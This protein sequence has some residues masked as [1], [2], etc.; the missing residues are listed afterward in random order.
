MSDDFS[1]MS[2]TVKAHYEKY[3][4]PDF[5]RLASVRVCDTYALNLESLWARFNGEPLDP[6][7]SRILLAGCGSFS[8]YPTAVANP[9][10]RITALD[11]S[12]TNLRKAKQ[13]T[14][15]H[16]RFNVDFIEG[17]LIE[18]VDLFGEE[19]FHFIDCYGV[20]HHMRDDASA[21]QTLHT[22]LKPG[23]FARIMVYSRQ[24]RR[25][26]QAIRWAMRLLQ[27]QDVRKL[28]ALCRSAKAGSRFRECLDATPEAA[29]DAGLA[30]LF[31][32]PYA[33]TYTLDALLKKLGRA[34]LEPLLF[35]HPGAWA[36]IDAEMARLRTLE[37]E[38]ALTA[39]FILF[40]GRQEDAWMRRGW[41]HLKARRATC[42]SLN[43]VIRK[44]LPL[45][46]ILPLKPAPKLGFENPAIDLCGK[47]LLSRFKKPV[48]RSSIEPAHLE[49][50]EKYLQALFLIET[51]S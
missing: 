45:F 38:R 1:A 23:A 9:K 35:I 8:P 39:N 46:P 27:I 3:V 14:W 42:I 10:A 2:M 29:F 19:S 25:S 12:K 24:A 28:K 36:D 4:Y 47:L 21:W 44:A 48:S 32:H 34:G 15:L 41:E 31:L 20:I 51:V 13:H 33:K 30:D 7:L 6:T 16:L 43:P 18:A 40:A 22:L 5:P 50:V 26:I 17:D 37:S 49:T 11:L